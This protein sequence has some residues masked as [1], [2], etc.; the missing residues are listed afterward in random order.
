MPTSEYD[1][2]F[3]PRLRGQARQAALDKALAP[4]FTA[5][6]EAAGDNGGVGFLGLVDTSLIRLLTALVAILAGLDVLNAVLMMTRERL[7]DLG[8]FKAI[9]M[10]PPQTIALVV[11][12][13]IAPATV[14]AAITLPARISL[15]N[16]LVRAIAASQASITGVT[17][18]GSL[19]HVCTASGMPC[20]RLS[21]AS[22]SPQSAA[23]G[24]ASWAAIAPT[25][26]ALRTE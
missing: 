15:Q 5:V 22:R 9:G 14:A 24:P 25:T 8:V 2:T 4:G 26:T 13:V 1:V 18:P 6:A 17:A 23:L 3:A 7:H 19:M 12:W 10:T 16:Q 21:S 20:S 11:C